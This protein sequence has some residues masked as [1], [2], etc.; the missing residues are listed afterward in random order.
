MRTLSAQ[1]QTENADNASSTPSAQRQ[2]LSTF[3]QYKK[4]LDTKFTSS[5]L[6]L[7]LPS[8]QQQHPQSAAIAQ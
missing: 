3:T 2:R 6:Y 5:L 7:Y 4:A 8:M 1:P